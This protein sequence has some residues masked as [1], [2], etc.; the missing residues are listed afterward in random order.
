MAFII[1]KTAILL[2]HF[3]TYYL[4]KLST[5]ISAGECCSKSN[6]LWWPNQKLRLRQ[7]PRLIT[8]QEHP[9]LNSDQ[10]TSTTLLFNNYNPTIL[11][12]DSAAS[13]VVSVANQ[14]NVFELSASAW[15]RFYRYTDKMAAVKCV[16]CT[17]LHTQRFCHYD[18][19]IWVL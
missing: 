19:T 4:F 2:L 9:A 17:S 7:P 18:G 6:T 10:K 14:K 16:K 11:Q 8:C 15:L 1:D 13:A 12:Y 3:I 5:Q